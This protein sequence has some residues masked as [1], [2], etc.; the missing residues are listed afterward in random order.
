[1]AGISAA[2]ALLLGTADW[3][4]PDGFLVVVSAS[5]TLVMLALLSEA[6][7]FRLKRLSTS[8]TSI[9]FIPYLASILLVGQGWSMVVAGLPMLL[10]EALRNKPFVK[11][12]HNTAKEMVAIGLAAQ[13]YHWLGGVPSL[14]E[15]QPAFTAFIG[16]VLV[17][18][19]LQQGATAVAVALS[20]QTRLREAWGRLAGGNQLYDLSASFIAVLLAFLYVRLDLW[21]ALLVAVPLLLVRHNYGMTLRFEQVQRDLLVLMVKSIEARDP[22]TSGHSVRVSRFARVMAEELGLSARQIDQ[23]ATAALLHDVGKIYQEFAPIL[24]K[25]GKL[26]PGE[27]CLMQSHPVKGAELIGTVSSLRGDVQ[28]AVRHHH[29]AFGGRGYPDRLSGQEIPLAARIIAVVDTFDA[30]TTTRPYRAALSREE[31]SAELQSMVGRQFDAKMVDLFCSSERIATVIDEALRERPPAGSTVQMAAGIIVG[32]EYDDTEESPTRRRW[33]LSS[34]MEHPTGDPSP[35][36]GKK[37][38]A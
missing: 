14:T 6:G 38:I 29:E 7:S 5:A 10:A 15:F 8:T 23:V 28:S 24:R 32:D 34:S 36:T 26:E 3:T 17:Y 25:E 18:F 9:A 19:P 22:Y 1:V 4:M 16:A 35:R 21:G 12:V 2:A 20:T 37:N 11:T 30:M 27:I 31:A 33:L 13:T